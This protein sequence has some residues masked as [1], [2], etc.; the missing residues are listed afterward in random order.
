MVT[1][2]RIT[3]ARDKEFDKLIQLYTE[4]FPLEERRGEDQL[5]RMLAEESRMYFNA[6][7]CDDK[8]SGLFVYWD[9]GTF[10]YLEHLAVY[11]EMRNSKIGQQT[12]DWIKENLNG[13]RIL[14]VEP[15][16]AEIA[17]R[18]IRYYERNGYNVYEKEYLQPAYRTGGNGCHLWVMCN[19]EDIG[20]NEKLDLLKEAVYYRGRC[21]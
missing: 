6:I 5:K 10:Y 16:E 15:A 14:E 13:L 20:L 9:F 7:S 11:A 21:S 4:A 3:D 1:L 12:L 2:R 18:R 17:I 19:R 8:L